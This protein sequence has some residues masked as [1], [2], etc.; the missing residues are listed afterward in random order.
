MSDHPDAE[1]DAR[2]AR[3][4]AA[5]AVGTSIAHELRNALAVVESSLFLARRDMDDRAR[6]LAHLEQAGAEVRKAHAV[7]GSVLGLARGEPIRQEPAQLS[8]L[9][10]SARHS[11]VLP[12]NVTFQVSVAPSEL[13]VSC[14]PVLFERVL[15]NLYQNAIDAL[16]GRGRG[17]IRT[18]AG[19]ADERVWLEVIDDGEGMTEDARA[20]IFEPIVSDKAAGAGLGLTLCRVIIDAH[21]GTIDVETRQDRGTTFHMTLPGPVMRDA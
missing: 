7:V 10:Q 4:I 9:I 21:G 13:M 1:D 14:D 3:L 20:R 15:T 6:L 17:A 11:V 8:T 18:R 5:G 12:T 19:L 16:A 2:Q